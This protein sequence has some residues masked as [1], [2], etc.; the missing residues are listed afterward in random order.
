M[1]V[2][3]DNL[4]VDFD[5]DAALY[6]CARGDRDALRRLYEREASRL[7]GV[8]LRIVRDRGLA[9]D[10]VHDAFVSIWSRAAS[11]D[12]ARGEGRG[13]IFS[14]V[15]NAALNRI[16]SGAR[17]VTLED[18]AVHAV[19][20]AAALAAYRGSAD[21]LE[22]RS[23]LGRLERCLDGLEPARRD[24]IVL[25]YVDGCSHSEIAQRTGTALGTVKSWIQRG[26]GSL[27]ECMA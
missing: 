12:A 19:D 8:A 4:L 5:Y 13:W 10:V 25:A 17:T 6:A 27:R 23:D 26:L 3:T 7:L 22:V 1:A 16:R 14:V 21:P 15:R 18:D 24:C 20:D 11:F 9:E 2:L